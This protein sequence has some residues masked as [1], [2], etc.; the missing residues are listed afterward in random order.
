VET[1]LYDTK[2]GPLV[3]SVMTRTPVG[4]SMES[5]VMSFVKIIMKNLSDTGLVARP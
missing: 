4:T 1:R 3:W 5:G 2:T